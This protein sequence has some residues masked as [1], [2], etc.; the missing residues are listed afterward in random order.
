MGD[1]VGRRRLLD[2]ARS[3]LLEQPDADLPDVPRHVVAS[4]RRSA[5]RGVD[6]GVIANQYH[7]DLDVQSRLVRCA[8]PVLEQLAEQV[9]DIPVC[10]ALTDDRARLLVRRDTTSGIGRDADLNNFAERFGYA[11]DAVGTNGVGTV[12]ESGESVHIVG[13]E[14]FVERLHG[15][16]CAGAPVHDPFSGRIEGVIDISCRAEHSSPVLHSLVRSAAARIRENLLRDRDPDQQALFDLYTRVE[17]RTRRAVLAVGRRT[18]LANAAMRTLLEPGDLVALQDHARFLMIGGPGVDDRIDLPSGARVRLRGSTV[19]VGG[20]VAGLAGEVAVVREA[21]G[22]PAPRI[23]ADDRA[24]LPSGSA[25]SPA[26][27][28]AGATAAEALRTGTPLLVVG[29]AGTG[30]RRLLEDLDRALHGT[31]GVLELAPADPV[32]E[33]AAGTSQLVVLSDIDRRDDDGARRLL[34]LFDRPGIRFA[35]TATGTTRRGPGHDALLARFR[36]S[37]TVPPLRSRI[38]DLPGL[39]GELLAELAPGREVRPSP[40]ALRTLTRYGWPGNVR[41]LRAALEAALDRRPV[42]EL[43]AADLPEF[44]QSAPRTSLRPV[45]QA[46]RDAIVAALR[47]SGGNRVAAAAALGFARSTLYRKIAR[48]RISS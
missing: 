48:Y 33:L 35:A 32:P 14:H 39:V 43:S 25:G 44:C 36:Q 4:W 47:D 17:A 16:A 15:Y 18:V 28:V 29:E 38:G 46:E 10:I 20:T 2:A 26:L 30:R 42:G 24:P 22:V 6:P 3:A 9:A 40:D 19:S 7:S 13:A 41:E 11:E 27:R 31:D 34:P 8:R 12:L 45:D 5:A 23:A 21:G 37:V 1:L